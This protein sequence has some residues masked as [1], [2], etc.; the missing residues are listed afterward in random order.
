MGQFCLCSLLRHNRFVSRLIPCFD[1]RCHRI[2]HVLVMFLLNTLMIQLFLV[3]SLASSCV[4]VKGQCSGDS[5]GIESPC[6]RISDHA[7]KVERELFCFAHW[8][9]AVVWVASCLQAESPYS[10][11]VS[12]KQ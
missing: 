6:L 7:D 5:L 9:T 8:S 10:S 1:L 2:V 4:S 11:S 12:Q 3:Y